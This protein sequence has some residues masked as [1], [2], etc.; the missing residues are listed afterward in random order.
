M[1]ILLG[2]VM[3]NKVTCIEEATKITEKQNLF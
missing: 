3:F 2:V 1:T